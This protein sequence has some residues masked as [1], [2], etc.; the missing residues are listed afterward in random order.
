M[1]SW[2]SLHTPVPFLIPA[3]YLLG[4]CCLFF[5]VFNCFGLVVCG[6]FFSHFFAHF[7]SFSPFLFPFLFPL[8]FSPFLFSFL[9]PF[10]FSFL[11]PFPIFGTMLD[12]DSLRIRQFAFCLCT[13][14]NQSPEPPK[15]THQN[16]WWKF[17]KC[18]MCP[19]GLYPCL[20]RGK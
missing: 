19:V 18:G 2:N 13:V 16:V 12:L 10:H 3:F 14:W 6:F 9:F 8:S 20:G 5:P 15:D 11:F 1:K 17:R 7:L 4:S